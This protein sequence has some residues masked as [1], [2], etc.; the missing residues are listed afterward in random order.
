VLSYF[1]T[2]PQGVRYVHRGAGPLSEGGRR[3]TNWINAN[4]K[5]EGIYGQAKGARGDSQGSHGGEN[6][7]GSSNK[8][9]TTIEEGDED[10]RETL[11][12]AARNDTPAHTFLHHWLHDFTTHGCRKWTLHQEKTLSRALNKEYVRKQVR[13]LTSIY[14]SA[15]SISLYL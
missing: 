6:D 7:T 9:A 4:L 11:A 12:D 13:L 1:L 8:V 3:N 14:N 5:F 15:P 2:V 10:M